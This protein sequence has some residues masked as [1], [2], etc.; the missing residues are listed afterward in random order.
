MKLKSV[1]LLILILFIISGCA[2]DINEQGGGKSMEKWC[3]RDEDLPWSG[4]W[5]EIRHIDCETGDEIESEEAIGELR[6]KP[7][8]GFSITWHPFE[9]YTD[10]T[11]SFKVNELEGSITFDKINT[12]GYDG[13]GF[14]LMRENG[15]LE[16]IDIWFG[17]FYSES[18]PASKP[19]ICGYV[20]RR[21]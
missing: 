9:F 7:D 14:Y 4:C 13:E 18:D 16:L 2:S 1:Y 12:P 19:I 20:F 5:R 6:L 11:G 3:Q 10:Y 8:G 21:K 15:D 17:S